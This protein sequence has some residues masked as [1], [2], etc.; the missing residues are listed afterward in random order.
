MGVITAPDAITEPVPGAR[1]KIGIAAVFTEMVCVCPLVADIIPAPVNVRFRL[2]IPR[3]SVA[4][5]TSK[6]PLLMV[7]VEICKSS[8]PKA[9]PETGVVQ[10]PIPEQVTVR[11]VLKYTLPTGGVID[12]STATRTVP[13]P[14]VTPTVPVGIR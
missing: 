12:V 4:P 5:L 1:V 13:L 9:A 7:Q 6:V 8:V 14:A 11:P 10:P 3:K 2:M